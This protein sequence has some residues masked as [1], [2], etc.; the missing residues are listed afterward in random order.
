MA[1][2]K[3]MLVEVFHEGKQVLQSV[4]L[5][6]KLWANKIY[7]VMLAT[8]DV[9]CLPFQLNISEVVIIYQHCKCV[10]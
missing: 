2:R 8:A 4:V 5:Q 9:S 3:F 7:K 10:F 1:K 6:H